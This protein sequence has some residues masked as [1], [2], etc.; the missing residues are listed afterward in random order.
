M[1]HLPDYLVEDLHVFWALFVF[2]VSP[3]EQCNVSINQG[4]KQT[5]RKCDTCMQETVKRVERQL[6]IS[7]FAINAHI[8]E[9]EKEAE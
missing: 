7:E 5:S 4:Y 9:S 3:Y 1:V 6:D 8:S 2:N